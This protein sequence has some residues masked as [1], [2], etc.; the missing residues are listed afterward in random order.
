M[1]ANIDISMVGEQAT[2]NGLS[3]MTG[4]T[5]TAMQVLAATLGV[6]AVSLM[7]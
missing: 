6:Q 4:Q 5:S 2:I 3:T 1:S 7:S